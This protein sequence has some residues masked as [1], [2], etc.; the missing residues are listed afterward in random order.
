MEAVRAR[1]PDA[2]IVTVGGGSTKV[3]AAGIGGERV[4]GRVDLETLGDALVAADVVLALR[5]PSRGETSGVLMRTLAAGRAAVI[6]SGSTADEDL[7][8]GVVAR[9]SPGPGEGRELAAVLEFLLTDADA[10]VRMEELALE[11]ARARGVGPLTERL[12]GFLHRIAAE[13]APLEARI[14]ARASRGAGVRGLIRNDLEAAASSLALA[15]LPS[16][17]FE[18]LA[19]L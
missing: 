15:H 4:M 2:V 7:P 16:N 6:S 12:S 1:V 14:Q 11:A 9:V 3:A 18:R 17:V 19:G 10:R 5:F 13:R 8:G